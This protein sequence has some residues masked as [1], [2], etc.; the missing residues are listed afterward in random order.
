MNLAII[1][2]RGIPNNYG[3]F[4]ELAEHISV[5]LHNKGYNVTVFNGSDH[6]YKLNQ[7]KGVN[8]ITKNNPEK[9]L[10]T[11]GQFI[12]DL[13]CIL[14]CRRKKFDVII[15]LG[16]TS[17]A[18]WNFL[19]HKKSYI[20][21]N[22]DGLEWKRDKYSFLVKIFLKIS[23]RIAINFSNT[24]VSDNLEIKKIIES[25]YKIKSNYI[26]YGSSLFEN[27][28]QKILLK[29]DLN[30][31]K[32]D[33]IIARMEPENNIESIIKGF[34]MAT[35]N[36][37]IDRK[38]VIVGDNMSKYSKYLKTKY[39]REINV[40][41]LGKIFDKN[42]L[43]NLRYYSNIY[44]HGHSVGGTNPSLIEAMSCKSC[45]VAHDNI[46]NKSVLGKDA[47]Y[48]NSSE[49]IASFVRSIDKKNNKSANNISL[50]KLN[51]NTSD[52]FNWDET[53]NNNYSKV[54]KNYSWSFIINEYEKLINE[55][56]K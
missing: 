30:P 27:P 21:T 16:Y 55:Y 45:I 42:I 52:V 29:Y 48:F 54:H 2:T 28:N 12:Y 17:S 39:L 32:Y 46:F 3:G 22:M 47:V 41:F 24:T 51:K 37:N 19:F 50:S 25:S 43:N 35:L 18:I 36:H 11:F 33:L 44:F 15:Q 53:I 14:E 6:N 26:A 4:E 8:I 5:G 38:L 56:E 23:E 1:G 49:D 34:S 20:I 9:K 7:Y 13:K 40:V 10:G 31:Y